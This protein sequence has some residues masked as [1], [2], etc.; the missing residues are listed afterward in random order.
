MCRECPSLLEEALLDGLLWHSK[1]VENGKIR[2]N[3]YI[4][5]MYGD[6]SKEPNVW[7]HPL[8]VLV[9]KGSSDMF[10]HPVRAF[11]YYVPPPIC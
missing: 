3:Y 11:T 4:R 6:T 9:G 5:E 8:A 7:K 2:V 10:Q 1:D